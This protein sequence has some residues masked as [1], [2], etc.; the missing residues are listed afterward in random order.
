[1]S[2]LIEHAKREF[3][4][5]GYN[6]NQKKEDPDKWIV[7]N[8]LEL[9]EVFSN[10]GHSGTSAPFCINYFKKLAMFEPLG[11]ITGEKSEWMEV[12]D[13]VFQN[14]R[15]SHVFK[16]N[17]QAYDIDGK[18]FREPNGV[19]Y[20]NKDSR[21]PVEFPYTPKSEYVDVDCLK[22]DDEN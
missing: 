12:G 16:E 15:C 18:I 5:I 19:C 3:K 17:G 20:T 1:M 11:P 13:G 2:N 21:V 8:V 14:K 9:L 7:E 4:A 6:L 10:Q 22:D